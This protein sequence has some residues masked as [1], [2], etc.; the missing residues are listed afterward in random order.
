MRHTRRPWVR[1]GLVVALLW[2]LESL[3]ATI[4]W[5]HPLGNFTVNHYSRIELSGDT[6]AVRYVLDF[7]EV[8]SVQERLG[9]DSDAD[10]T[11]SAAEWDAYKQRK[12]AEILRNLELSIDSRP[13]QLEVSDIAV[14]QPPG[15][16]DIPLVRVEM[17]FRSSSSIAPNVEHRA[18]L[19]DRTDAARIGW[20][21]MVVHA[22]RGA[23]ITDSDAPSQDLTDELR[24]YPDDMLQN[25]LDRRDANWSFSLDG[26]AGPVTLP[27][28]ATAVT[29][30]SDPFAALVTA[31]DLNPAV[32]VLALLG[33][34]ALGGIH[35]ASPGHGKTMMAAYLVGTRGTILHAATLAMSVTVAHTLG[36]LVLG[37][38]T[39]L[40]S[41]LIFP[42]RLYPWLTLT[43]GAVVLIVGGR[44]L[45]LALRRGPA[46]SHPSHAHDHDHD[47]DHADSGEPDHVHGDARH[48]HAAVPPS[49]RGLFALGLAGG[50]VPSGSAL[51]VLLSS[52]ALGRLGFGLTLIVAFGL[53][54]AVVLVTTGVLLVHA[55]RLM[56]RLF[57]RTQRT[58][59]LAALVPLL[60]AVLMTLLGIATTVEGLSQT[61]LIG[62]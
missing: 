27:T 41:N 5:A 16:G 61:G 48:T 36:V 46:H 26:S 9:A 23:T 62:T 1:G 2:L 17:W 30:P 43:S 44:F 54:M 50:I 21:E 29:R 34:A 52:V 60:S 18:T 6:L 31:T 8:P 40:A 15:Q 59:R 25:P 32:I 12:A 24:S 13:A 11:V 38:L 22:G 33:A 4:V 42:D 47:H 7:A 10:G 20:R 53:G 19:H 55:G 56:L 35:A 28:S 49:W 45:I 3:S 37:V 57:P 58:R 14:S 39:V 51:V